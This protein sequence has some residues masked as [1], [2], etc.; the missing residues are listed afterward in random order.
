M[1]KVG[2]WLDTREALLFWDGKEEV[3]K[4]TSDI[5]EGHVHGGYGGATKHLP[6]DAVSD[7]KMTAYKEEQIK[8]YFDRLV[9]AV[10]SANEIYIL[11]PGEIRKRF[12]KYLTDN[13]ELGA[14]VFT[15]KPLDSVTE[16]Q[17]WAKF[18]ELFGQ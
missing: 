12:G 6:Q 10:S 13:T 7:T 9:E 4:M 3:A 1:K 18:Q 2:I 5:D 16:G 8:K 15:N 17:K 11:G 14:R